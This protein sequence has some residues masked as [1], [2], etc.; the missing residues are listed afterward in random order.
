[1]QL[2]DKDFTGVINVG[3]QTPCSKYDF[4]M[5]LAEEF[6]LNLSQI[7]KGS[8]AVHSFSAPRF[9]KLDMNVSKLSCLDITPPEYRL[10]ISQFA[11]DRKEWED[12]Y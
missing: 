12:H 11:Q 10:S 2:I 9:R 4:G 1:M 8:I 7:R 5:Q 6:E 3:S